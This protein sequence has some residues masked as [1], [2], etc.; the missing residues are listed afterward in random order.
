VKALEE[1][2]ACM[3]LIGGGPVKVNR[4]DLSVAEINA[5]RAKV[6]ASTSRVV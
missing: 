6:G 4:I 1:N 3:K 5:R 2:E